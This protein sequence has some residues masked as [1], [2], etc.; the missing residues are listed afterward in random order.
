MEVGQFSPYSGFVCFCFCY[1]HQQAISG[2]EVINIGLKEI[3]PET[4]SSITQCDSLK[5]HSP[6]HSRLS[7]QSS[8]TRLPSVSA[9][10]RYA[11]GTLG[12]GTNN[13]FCLDSPS[14]KLSRNAQ[15]HRP[16]HKIPTANRRDICVDGAR[17]TP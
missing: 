16:A 14:Y 4:K 2:V 5:A 10:T 9:G 8:P 1:R 13:Q 6:S 3:T 11:S 7:F 17:R 15:N 12:T